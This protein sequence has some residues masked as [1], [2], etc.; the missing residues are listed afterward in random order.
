MAGIFSLQMATQASGLRHCMG[1]LSERC[2][3][4]FG[5]TGWGI[6]LADQATIF[7]ELCQVGSGSAK[8]DGPG[9]HADEEV[10]RAPRRAY[11]DLERDGGGL[12]VHVYAPEE[13]REG[14]DQLGLLSGFAHARQRD[15]GGL[16]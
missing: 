16:R 6:A 5:D 10:R 15:D 7:E 13:A 14:S 3:L 1:N 2:R 8:G 4:A 12:D 11:L 9:T